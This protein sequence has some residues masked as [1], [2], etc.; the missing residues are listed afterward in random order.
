MKTSPSRPIYI[1]SFIPCRSSSN[2]ALFDLPSDDSNSPFNTLLKTALLA[3]NVLGVLFQ[4]I[5][6]LT[7][8]KSTPSGIFTSSGRH[9][10]YINSSNFNIFGYKIENRKPLPSLLPFWF[11][12]QLSGL[13]RS[14]FKAPRKV[15]HLTRF[16]FFFL[17]CSQFYLCDGVDCC[18][19]SGWVMIGL[20]IEC[21]N[22]FD[23]SNSWILGLFL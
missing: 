14:M 2:F 22:D 21:G 5:N 19:N 3:M 16:E 17:V 9:I 15:P 6:Q 20:I 8:E 12:D 10:S 13:S 4:S 7:P 11:D 18:G 23:Y 1:D